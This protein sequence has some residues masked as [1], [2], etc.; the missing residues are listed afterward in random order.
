M[1]SKLAYLEPRA[2]EFL[3]VLRLGVQY[4]LVD[5]ELFVAADEGQIG[6]GTGL[7]E[8]VMGEHVVRRSTWKG[9]D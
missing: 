6:E 7:E 5:L 3:E 1:K 8:P 2:E 9:R 4:D